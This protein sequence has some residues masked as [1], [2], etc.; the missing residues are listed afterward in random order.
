MLLLVKEDLGES[1]KEYSLESL[2]NMDPG[3]ALCHSTK[4]L[5]FTCGGAENINYQT[6]KCHFL[7]TAIQNNNRGH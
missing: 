5:V 1:D 2:V 3:P 6:N 4:G 7:Q